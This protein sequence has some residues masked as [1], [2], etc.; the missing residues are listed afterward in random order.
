MQKTLTATPETYAAEYIIN[1]T[2]PRIEKVLAAFR[3]NRSQLIEAIRA[4]FPEMKRTSAHSSVY[5]STAS[6]YL[7]EILPLL[8]DP[9]GEI[10]NPLQ[11]ENEITA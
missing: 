8:T 2:A 4:Q 9:L 5:G 7:Y 10:P 1:L 6:P 11:T 3:I